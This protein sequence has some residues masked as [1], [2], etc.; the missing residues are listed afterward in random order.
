MMA[1]HWPLEVGTV[2]YESGTDRIMHGYCM[3]E[4]K[5]MNNSCNKEKTQLVN[6]I[7][8]ITFSSPLGIITVKYP[9]SSV[10]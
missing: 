10:S 7:Y 6:P 1:W 9:K 8:S 4:Q 3:N 5:F 2:F